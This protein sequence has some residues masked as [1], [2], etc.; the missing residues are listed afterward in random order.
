MRDLR[1]DLAKFFDEYAHNVVYVR[2]DPRFRCA[3]Y[4]ERSGEP[5]SNCPKCFGTSYVVSMEKVR[6]RRT[7]SSFPESLPNTNR[8]AAFGSMV[9][10]QYVYYLEHDINPKENDLIL[11]VQWDKGMPV[12]IMQKHSISVAEPLYG[13]G[14]R[15][16]FWVTY[17]KHSMG[18]AGDNAALTKY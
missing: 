18:E 16:E 5:T 11:E 7:L 10:K 9:P 17:L 14:G 1:E 2:R 3:C 4:S 15:V 8:S 6:T 12:R 13:K